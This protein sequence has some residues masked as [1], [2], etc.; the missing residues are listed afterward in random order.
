MMYVLLILHTYVR[1]ERMFKKNENKKYDKREKNDA[2][3]EF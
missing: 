3:Y 1:L 2:F